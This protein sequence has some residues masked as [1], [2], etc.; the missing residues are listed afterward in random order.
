MSGSDEAKRRP[1]KWVQI[2]MAYALAVLAT[3]VGWSQSLIYKET[4]TVPLVCWFPFVVLSSLEDIAGA[5][6]SLVQ[7][8]VL[9]TF[10]AIG[11]QFWPTRRVLV[12][13]AGGYAVAVAVA[14]WA[15]PSFDASH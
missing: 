15:M 10:F 11:I 5:V 14:W 9:A 8:P 6:V 1:P 4:P 7:F 13:M 2:L 3:L 12:L